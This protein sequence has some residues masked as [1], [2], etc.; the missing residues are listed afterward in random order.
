MTKFNHQDAPSL[1]SAQELLNTS[2]WFIKLSC[3]AQGKIKESILEI[4]IPMGNAL[5]TR[6]QMPGFWYGVIDGLLKWSVTSS[7]GRTVSLGGQLSG[8]W[9]GEGTLIRQKPRAADVIALRNCKLAL[10]PL[11]IF[12]WLR[13]TQPTFNDFLLQQITERLHW[14]MG[15]HVDH[16]LLGFD[17]HVARA[18]CGL[19]HNLHNPN[20]TMHL[21]ISQEELANMAA[22]SRPRCN[23]A[24]CKMRKQGWIRTE[25]GGIT[26]LNVVALNNLAD[27]GL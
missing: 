18:L 26:L 13:K 12:Q 27:R 17:A 4:D 24:L 11:D 19:L 21:R 9:F 5:G 16:A 7:D 2:S 1:Q 8:S 20:P 22:M 23:Q 3:D 14:F 15:K 25:Y 6:G 10:M